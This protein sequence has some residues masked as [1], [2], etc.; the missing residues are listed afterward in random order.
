[1]VKSRPP[2]VL[3]VGFMSHIIL[4]CP[5]LFSNLGLIWGTKSGERINVAYMILQTRGSPL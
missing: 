5:Y 1:M 2:L 4:V 3:G